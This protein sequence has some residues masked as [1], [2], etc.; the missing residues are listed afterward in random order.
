[1]LNKIY[2]F[3][4]NQ[5]QKKEMKKRKGAFISIS[6][7]LLSL[8]ELSFVQLILLLS[9]LITPLIIFLFCGPRLGSL[10]SPSLATSTSSTP[11]FPTASSSPSPKSMARSCTSASASSPPSSSPSRARPSHSSRP[12]TRPSPPGRGSWFPI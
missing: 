12:T 10:L 11:P 5:T 1:M 2:I 6:S 9:T 4:I 7:S 8:M 3:I